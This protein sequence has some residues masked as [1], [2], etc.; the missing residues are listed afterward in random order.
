MHIRCSSSNN[1][2]VTGAGGAMDDALKRDAELGPLEDMGVSQ[3]S[4]GQ[5]DKMCCESFMSVLPIVIL[6]VLFMKTVGRS[7]K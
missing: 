1:K 6:W 2:Q 4:Y 3:S 7:T 5:A